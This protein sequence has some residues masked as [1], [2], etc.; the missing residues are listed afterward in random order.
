MRLLLP[1][2]LALT[3]GFVQGQETIQFE[4]R[5]WTAA[6]AVE[7]EDYLGRPALRMRGGR[8][9]LEGVEFSNGTIEFDIAVTGHRS[10]VGVSFRRSPDGTRSE[11]FYL[12]PHQTGRFDALQYTPVENGISA[13]QLFPEYNAEVAIPANEWIPVRLVVMGDRLE[14]FVGTGDAPAL[15]SQLA[16]DRTSGQMALTS[17]VPGG[18]GGNAAPPEIMTTAYSNIRITPGSAPTA[19]PSP[20][21]P[22]DRFI[23]QWELSPSAP[24]PDDSPTELTDGMVPA[25]GWTRAETD[26]RGRVNLAR[27]RAIPRGANRG[28]VLARTTVSS[29]RDRVRQLAIGFSDVGS[30]FVNGSLVYRANNTYLSRS[31]RYLGVMTLNDVIAIPLNAGTNEIVVAVSESFGG[32]GLMARWE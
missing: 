24:A 3:P 21:R 25:D 19:E 22:D 32:W 13:W 31:G 11:F 18:S 8:A 29:D 2:A 10:F 6:G 5:S 12:R 28:M 23:T 14:V 7:V 30:V 9:L 16:T 20:A 17:G 1:L 15:V 26:S 27:Y 4:D